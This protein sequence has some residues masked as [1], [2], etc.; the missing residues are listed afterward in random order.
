LA[1]APTEK[2][3]IVDLASLRQVFKAETPESGP[4]EAR[5]APLRWV[6]TH[7]MLA[8]CMTKVMKADALREVLKSG[9]LKI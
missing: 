5:T 1:K 7:R 4:V 6:P 2:R 8:D 3:L 9:R